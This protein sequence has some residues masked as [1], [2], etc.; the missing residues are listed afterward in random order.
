MRH[1]CCK[2]VNHDAYD[3]TESGIMIA[4]L[5]LNI[6]MLEPSEIKELHEDDDFLRSQLD[7]L[8]ELYGNLHLR[9]TTNT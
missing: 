1:T 8:M 5:S 7:A 2:F 9:Y 4:Y 3:I 6:E